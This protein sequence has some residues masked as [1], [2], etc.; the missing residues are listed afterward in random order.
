MSNKSYVGDV[1]TVLEVDCGVNI[2]AASTH[3]I[4]MQKPDLTAV[5]LTGTIHDS[6]YIRY[7]TIAGDLDQ[8]GIYRVQSKIV[9][10]GWEGLG[11]TAKL[12]I[13]GHYE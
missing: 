6:N 3:N 12:R 4:M 7:T 11:E 8:S 2:S 9:N 13:Y 5:E 1:G 10:S